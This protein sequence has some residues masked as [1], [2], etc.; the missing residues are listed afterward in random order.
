MEDEEE[1]AKKAKEEIKKQK[2]AIK[3]QFVKNKD[4]PSKDLIQLA[5]NNSGMPK[6]KSFLE[7]LK[8]KI[9]KK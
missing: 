5:R 4:L 3:S 6:K 2:G 8:Q 1:A 9:T 7:S